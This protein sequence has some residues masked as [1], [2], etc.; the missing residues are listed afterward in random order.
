MSIDSLKELENEIMNLEKQR[1]NN[2]EWA[3]L[4]LSELELIDDLEK[5][6]E[7]R[8]KINEFHMHIINTFS[9]LVS[10][11]FKFSVP[12]GK[13]T[14]RIMATDYMNYFYAKGMTREEIV[15]MMVDSKTTKNSGKKQK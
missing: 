11:D 7:Y 3:D 2:A 10:S 4:T 13:L 1:I 5:K 12:N 9:T 14:Y 15:K 8:K 6:K